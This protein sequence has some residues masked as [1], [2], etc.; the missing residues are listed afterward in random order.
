MLG[1]GEADIIDI[2]GLGIKKNKCAR[3]GMGAQS[4]ETQTISEGREI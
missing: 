2:K 4:N 1:V 3:F